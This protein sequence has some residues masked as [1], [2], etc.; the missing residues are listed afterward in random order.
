MRSWFIEDRYELDRLLALPSST[1]GAELRVMW[2]VDYLHKS[3]VIKASEREK[4][5]LG[6]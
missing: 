6:I 1:E 2:S 4:G 3:H 5:R